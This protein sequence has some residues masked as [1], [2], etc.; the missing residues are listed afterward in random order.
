[1]ERFDLDAIA[2][3]QLIR[4]L[5]QEMNVPVIEVARRL[6]LRELPGTDGKE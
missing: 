2:G 6:A 1:M 3:F 4:T 5:S